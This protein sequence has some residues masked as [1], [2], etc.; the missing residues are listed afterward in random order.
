MEQQSSIQQPGLPIRA[1]LDLED[2]KKIAFELYNISVT[3]AKEL[4]G[5]DDRNY[6]LVDDRGKEI[7]LKIINLVDSQKPEIY[8]AQSLLLE[9]LGKNGITCSSPIKTNDNQYFVLHTF[10]SGSHIVRALKFIK[11]VILAKVPWTLELFYQIGQSAARLDTTMKTFTHP[12]YKSYK[13]LWILESVPEILKFL[14]AVSDTERR[15]LVTIIV[16]EFGD[17]VLL[18]SKSLSRG[19]IH[20]DFNEQNII[21]DKNDKGSYEIK[22]IIDYGDCHFGCYLYEISITMVYMMLLAKSIEAG[23]AVLAGYTSIMPLS[24]EEY[25]LLKVCAAARLCQSLVMGAYAYQQDP[26]NTYVIVTAA[27]GWQL[28]QDLWN[29]DDDLLLERWNNYVV[30]NGL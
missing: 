26:S 29:E 9:H 1:T 5:Y 15:E 6:H 11:G 24:N 10:K 4:N 28:L 27:Y 30:N 20:G 25:R 18:S 7:V 16:K 3:S 17:K 8:E 22:A 14:S 2:V 23:G 12:A 13:S 21:V 19:L